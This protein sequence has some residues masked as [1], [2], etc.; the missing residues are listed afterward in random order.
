[1]NS[2]IQH[3]KKIIN[4]VLILILIV[5]LSTITIGFFIPQLMNG[6][7][8]N[9]LKTKQVDQQME[10][11]E[12]S[13]NIIDINYTSPIRSSELLD[14]HMY[15]LVKISTKQL[16]SLLIHPISKIHLDGITRWWETI[17]IHKLSENKD[18]FNQPVNINQTEMLILHYKF[19][20]IINNQV[21][22][23]GKSKL[24]A[25]FAFNFGFTNGSDGNYDV[26]F[27]WK[28]DVFLEVKESGV[29]NFII[30]TYKIKNLSLIAFII[31]AITLIKIN[32]KNEVMER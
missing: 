2:T 19:N 23:T 6:S 21:L 17:N 5:L 30:F 12:V 8:Q 26:E 20:G 16:S 11:N 22:E 7:N 28:N 13:I 3:H 27:D 10:T 15:F 14:N 4:L 29:D 18:F 24:D 25:A 9:R 32:R 31:I 1:M